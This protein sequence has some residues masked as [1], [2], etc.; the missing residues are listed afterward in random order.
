MSNNPAF[1]SVMGLGSLKTEHGPKHGAVR[2][3]LTIGFLLALA[4]AAALGIVVYAYYIYTTW[5][6]SR[7]DNEFP[8]FLILGLVAIG[9]GGA[10]LWQAWRAFRQRGLA[11][12]VYEHGVAHHASNTVQQV[13]WEQVDSIFQNVTRHYY[14]GIYTGTTHIYTVVTRDKQRLVFDDQLKNVDQIGG[15]LQQGVSNAL[16]PAYVQAINSGQ[17]VQFGPLGLD[18]ERI[19]SGN[20]SL[21]WAEIKAIKLDRGQIQVKKEGGWF[22]W[23]TAS[24]PQI[25]NFF[26][27]YQLIR[28]FTKVE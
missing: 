11:V 9:S 23:S 27:F 3:A 28:N 22:N 4:A 25:P 18:R 16:Y 24:V 17:R 2:K 8:A 7:L 5:G 10:G 12:A 13:R 19:Y 26:V 14:N 1:S 15:A 6:A 21:T 20:K